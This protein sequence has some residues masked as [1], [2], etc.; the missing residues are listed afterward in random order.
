M[1]SINTIPVFFFLSDVAL[2]AGGW[3]VCLHRGYIGAYNARQLLVPTE[4][5]AHMRGMTGLSECG[6]TE[7][8]GR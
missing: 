2:A 4:A 7:R 5:R 3:H 1:S 6:G 8:G